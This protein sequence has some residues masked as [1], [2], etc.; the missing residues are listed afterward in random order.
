MKFSL[1]LILLFLLIGCAPAI[2]STP[3]PDSSKPIRFL[4]L[5]DSYT[6]GQS[7]PEA[8]RW[9]V[10]LI[11]LIKASPHFEKQNGGI[12]GGIIARTGWTTNE[13]WQAIQQNPPQGTYELVSLL[14][15]VNDEYRGG[16][17]Q[18]YRQD[19]RFLLG[20]AIGYAGGDAKRVI[21]LSIPDWG[22]TPFAQNDPRPATQIS[23]EIDAFNAI[24][25]DESQ[26][27]GVRY[28]DVTPISRQAPAD[29]ALIADDGLHPSGKMYAA[30]AALALPEALSA[31]GIK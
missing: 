13:L 15:G 7:V 4:A 18:P 22:V 26:K 1:L 31:L 9:P 23:A 6:I 27:A 16:G 17:A 5:G 30:W 11:N 10:Q 28:V 24:N 2:S 21:V 8:E 25:K 12:E 19:F 3:M 29:P 14:I 20:K